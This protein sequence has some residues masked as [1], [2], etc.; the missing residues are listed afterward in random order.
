M[1]LPTPQWAVGCKARSTL[2][3]PALLPPALHVSSQHPT[4]PSAWALPNPAL[5][6][7]CCKVQCVSAGPGHVSESSNS[8]GKPSLGCFM[9][10][11]TFTA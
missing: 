1:L 9:S 7:S 2:L 6:T 5:L 10:T 4:L 3:Q 11:A 8:E